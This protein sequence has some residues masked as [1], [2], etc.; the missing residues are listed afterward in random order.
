M[1][2]IFLGAF[3]AMVDVEL[4]SLGCLA[5][6]HGSL[7]LQR[8]CLSRWSFQVRSGGDLGGGGQMDAVLCAFIRTM[9]LLRRGFVDVAWHR[10]V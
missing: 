4:K 6:D 8:Y 1:I 7:R 5:H 9:Q 3:A 10:L 2:E